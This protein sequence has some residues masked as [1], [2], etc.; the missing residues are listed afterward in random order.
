M[1]SAAGG[2]ILRDV[3]N[4]VAHRIGVARPSSGGVS[5]ETLVAAA[6]AAAASAAASAA[7]A[8]DDLE[9]CAELSEWIYGFGHFT[10]NCRNVRQQQRPMVHFRGEGATLLDSP[11]AE[12][13]IS[14]CEGDD[15]CIRFDVDTA[16]AEAIA[17][18]KTLSVCLYED[19]ELKWQS[20]P[21]EVKAAEAGS[22]ASASRRLFECS[23]PT[24]GANL[25]PSIYELR[26]CH[27]FFEGSAMWAKA[28]ARWYICD[29]PVLLSVCLPAG[30]ALSDLPRMRH[31]LRG[32]VL[33]RNGSPHL[34][35]VAVQFPCQ[36]LG[37]PGGAVTDS[38]LPLRAISQ[39]V[40]SV[41]DPAGAEPGDTVLA[42]CPKLQLL[43]F[44]LA[45]D[46]VD[47]AAAAYESGFVQVGHGAYSWWVD[48][49]ASSMHMGATCAHGNQEIT[50]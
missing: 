28:K 9:V 44:H 35:T 23:A 36:Y 3:L 14:I 45:R 25:P 11:D 43:R 34:G 50:R 46:N 4:G 30:P 42:S 16:R 27:R 47:P 49:R 37:S 31:K 2:N 26:L 38:Q 40:G 39:V 21:G 13:T 22:S 15:L 10:Q 33:H 8:H 6:N 18:A 1:L 41:K 19:G 24:D 7:A 20:K 12:Q 29:S 48:G 32:V 17:D 5:G